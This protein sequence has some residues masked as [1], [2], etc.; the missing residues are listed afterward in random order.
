MSEGAQLKNTALFEGKEFIKRVQAI[1]HNHL[2]DSGFDVHALCR[3]LGM[4]RTPLHNKL[5]ALTG[6]SATEYIRAV[7]LQ[8]ARRLLL[9]TDLPV[10]KIVCRTGFGNPNYFSTRFKEEFGLSPGYFRQ[11]E[12]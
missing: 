9:Q 2:S 1:I 4:A 7:R 8:Y 6:R 10:S 3:E 5:K 11:K 12:Q